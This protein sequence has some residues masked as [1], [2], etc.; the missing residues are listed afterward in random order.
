MWNY[1]RNYLIECVIAFVSYLKN[2]FTPDDYQIRY[3]RIYGKKD[4]DAKETPL[5]PLW[6]D[7]VFDDDICWMHHSVDR[8]ESLDEVLETAPSWLNDIQIHTSFWYRGE[9][10]IYIGTDATWPPKECINRKPQFSLPIK[11]A[12]LISLDVTENV[13]TRINKFAGPFG[14][15]YGNPINAV[16]FFI[17]WNPKDLAQFDCLEIVDILGFKKE[18]D[19]TIQ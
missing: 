1:L 18:H 19:I 14:D 17:K 8:E 13:T 4:N 10:K 9:K 11:H 7:L 12:K 5:A 15:F 2:I 6:S 16:D 3:V